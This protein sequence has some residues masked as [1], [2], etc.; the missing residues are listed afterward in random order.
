MKKR[1]II[2]GG[3]IH[4]LSC[5]ME[6]ADL[7]YEI[8]LIEKETELFQ[9]T[10]GAT[11][12]RAH[13]G[14]HYPRAENTVEECQAG[15]N[16]FKHKFKEA[17]IYPD[18]NYYLISKYNSMSSAAQF[19]SFCKK[20]NLPYEKKW[21]EK[22][23]L[24]QS[25]M[26]QSFLVPE[27]VFDVSKLI[28]IFNRYVK[29]KKIILKTNTMLLKG[30]KTPQN[31]FQ[32]MVNEQGVNKKYT[33]DLV[34]N[35]TYAYSN[36]I[37][38]AFGLEQHMTKYNLQIVEVAVVRCKQ[39]IPALTIMD[40]PF[41][42]I[43]PYAR[44]TDLYLVYDVENSVNYQKQTYLLDDSIKCRS[45]WDKMNQKGKIYFPFMDQLEYIKSL[46]AYRPIPLHDDNKDRSTKIESYKDCNGFYSILEGKFISA[47]L[48]AKQLK[49]LIQTQHSFL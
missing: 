43:M 45:N 7:D 6:L 32:I 2:I 22:C 24:E 34:I 39:K 14:Y 16:L 18:S 26:S 21:P 23:F 36:N 29:Q 30:E 20:F 44:R 28:D 5:A 15:L 3:G 27:P 41:I 12:N 35:A 31:T 33:G 11:H 42:S 4:G 25:L 38:K 13:M 37:L 40:G 19:E 47:L 49:T 8:V 10:S 46:R 17:L 48:I 9:G 1:I